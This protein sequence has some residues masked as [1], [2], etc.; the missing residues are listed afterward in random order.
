MHVA[1]GVEIHY[2]F[3]RFVL[4]CRWADGYAKRFGLIYVDYSDPN[5]TRYLKDSAHWYAKYI[6]SAQTAA[7]WPVAR[8]NTDTKAVEGE[9]FEGALN[10]RIDTTVSLMGSGVYSGAAVL[11]M[12]LLIT[13]MMRVGRK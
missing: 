4:L 2:S 11:L 1:F 8:P 12:L 7:Q 6:H 13:C 10:G 3:H 9:Y 5:R